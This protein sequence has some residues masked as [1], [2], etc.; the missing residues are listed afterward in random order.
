MAAVAKPRQSHV[1]SERVSRRGSRDHLSLLPDSG[2]ASLER[3]DSEGGTLRA[4]PV[5]ADVL[6][7]DWRGA[8]DAAEAALRAARIFLPAR[9]HGARSAGLTAER[10]STLGLLKALAREEGESDRFLHLTPRRDARRVL[11]LPP[12]VSACVFNLEGVLIGSAVLHAAAWTE[13]LDEFIWARTE[14]SGG[15]FA[16]FNPRTDYAQHIHDKPR[17]DG[18]RDFLASRG[19]SLPEG[20]PED[21]PGTETV[22][23]LA[24]R[25][26][27]AL[28]RRLAEHGVTAYEGS[29]HY[30]ETALEGG[31]HTAAVSASANTRTILEHA[32]LATLIECSV[33][34][35]TMLAEHLRGNPAPDTLLAASRQLGLEPE[36]AAAFETS[37]AGVAAARAGGCA[38]VVGVDRAGHADALR[39]EGA[40]LVV[41]GLAELLERRLVA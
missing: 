24:N 28:L 3:Q 23:G 32:G 40:D 37:P 6:C 38:F 19:I 2:T 8:L 34:G 33:D 17:L 22:H 31:L 15:R 11:A 29:R 41:P 18:V 36:H 16:P 7:P 10:V 35:N 26:N 27:Q 1:S 30:L 4:R 21:P 14:R 12:G 9:E 13:T 5:T 25:K 39:A 20:N